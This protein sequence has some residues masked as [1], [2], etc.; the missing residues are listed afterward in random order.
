MATDVH[1]EPGRESAR[2]GRQAPAI[3]DG[4]VIGPP[5][6]IGVGVHK[7]GTTWWWAL[8]A[9][10]PEID[11][12]ARRKELHLLDRMREGPISAEQREWYYRQFPRLPGH[13]AGEWT[14][15]YMAMPP[16][17]GIIREVAPEAKLLTIVREPVERYRSGLKQWQEQARRRSL[18]RD[19]RIGKREALMRGFY[20]RQIQRL[21][22]VLGRDRLL[23]LQYERCVRAPADELARTLAF[24]GV[25]PYSPD[26]R[27]LTRR[28]NQ[29]LGDKGTLSAKEEA[30]LV[31]EYEPEV[32]LLK[33]L[34]PDIDLALWPRFSH[35]EPG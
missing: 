3:P 18:R 6:F 26:E 32:A 34:V 2:R 11:A 19:D 33:E 14:P 35:L 28:Y 31:A 23:V 8:L 17:P 20:G 21:V 25:S 1:R 9:G 30:D 22:D 4:A 24:L 13:L 29:T 7:A 12:V 10:H 27:L 15:R 5:D 16:I